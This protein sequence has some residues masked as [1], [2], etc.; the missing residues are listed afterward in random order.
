VPT[1]EASTRRSAWLTT[2]AFGFVGA[3]LAGPIFKSGIWDPFE[4]RSLELARRIAL[5]LYGATGLELAGV[6]NA[7]PTRGEVDRGELPFTAMALGLRLF[8]L[9][10]WAG[11]LPVVVAALLGLAA[12]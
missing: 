11:G 12:T 3:T 7:L 9:H 4:L 8:G 6:S 10:A 1:N 5:G 2:A